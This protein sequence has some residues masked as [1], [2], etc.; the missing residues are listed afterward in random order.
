MSKRALNNTPDEQ[1]LPTGDE[2]E[3]NELAE[4]EEEDELDPEELQVSSLDPTRDS[5][6]EFAKLTLKKRELSLELRRINDLLAVLEQQA[7]IRLAETGYKSLTVPAGDQQWYTLTAHRIPWVYPAAGYG[8]TDV[9]DALDASQLGAFVK[10]VY[11]TQQLTTY[12]RDME[13]RYADD[14]KAQRYQSIRELL[15]APLVRVVRIEPSYRIQA[16][17]AAR[18]QL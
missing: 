9:C 2:L 13:E 5:F 6:I 14:L 17:K 11:S 1:E 10:R 15:P 8:R 18:R 12:V 16:R 4:D 3:E 7:L